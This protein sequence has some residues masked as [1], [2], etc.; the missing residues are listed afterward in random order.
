[1][2]SL[3]TGDTVKYISDVQPDYTGQTCK[4]FDFDLKHRLM[5]L[6]FDDGQTIVAFWDEVEY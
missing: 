5:G 3:N 2:V 1:M 4:V 6:K